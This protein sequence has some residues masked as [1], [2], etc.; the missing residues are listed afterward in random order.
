M[1][2]ASSSENFTGIAL[3]V[4]SYVLESSRY[5]ENGENVIGC[6]SLLGRDE[7]GENVIG[8]VS[9]LGRDE[10]G[11]NVIGCVSLLGHSFPETYLRVL[12][13]AVGVQQLFELLVHAREHVD[14]DGCV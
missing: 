12:Q 14:I 7:N 11:E 10:N 1:C 9:L 3:I 2:C 6:V 8:C 5:D 4:F 13:V